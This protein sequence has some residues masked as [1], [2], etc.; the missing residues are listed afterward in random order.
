MTESQIRGM[1]P[2]W[3][4]GDRLAKALRFNKVGVGEMA[5]YL[6]V[7]RNTIGN[8]T[9]GRTPVDKRTRMLWAMRTGVPVEWLEHGTGPEHNGPDD[10]EALRRLT[11]QKVSKRPRV[12]RGSTKRYA[13]MS[14]AA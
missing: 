9:S 12:T 8:Y 2:E 13:A 3:T 1:I 14:T 6:G 10:G 7:S 4:E 11:E 5:D